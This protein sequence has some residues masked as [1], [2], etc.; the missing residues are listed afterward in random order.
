MDVVKIDRDI[1]LLL[2][3]Q[4]YCVSSV[5]GCFSNMLQGYVSNFSVVS[6]VC[7]KCFI[8]I[9]QKKSGYCIVVIV[10]HV[11][12]KRLFPMFHLFF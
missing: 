12:C 2:R 8:R 4:R 1:A 9:L 11:C 10:V 5:S 6:D 7:F 3:R